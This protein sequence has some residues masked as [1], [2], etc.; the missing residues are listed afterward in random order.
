MTRL[1]I[2]MTLSITD[3]SM[4]YRQTIG[5]NIQIPG[6]LKSKNKHPKL[7]IIASTAPGPL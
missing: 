3:K 6:W 7:V 1:G 4:F 2:N 5:G